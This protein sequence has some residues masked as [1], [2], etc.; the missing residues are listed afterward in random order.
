MFPLNLALLK[1][2]PGCVG[3]IISA[4][5]RNAGAT[6]L[7]FLTVTL[8]SFAET[9]LDVMNRLEHEG[10]GVLVGVRLLVAVRVTVRVAVGVKVAVS[11]GRSVAV[12]VKV[13]VGVDVWVGV[14]VGVS[15]WVGVFVGMLKPPL[16]VIVGIP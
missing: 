3:Q 2:I 9:V 10:A 15:V 11:V 6:T 8:K 4:A 12:A 14:K 16:G 5:V 7:S 1:L 13:E